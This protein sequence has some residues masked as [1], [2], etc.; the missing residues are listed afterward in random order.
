MNARVLAIALLP[1]VASCARDDGSPDPPV[2]PLV[3]CDTDAG[4]G[5]PLACPPAA[6][7]D[8]SASQND[9]AA[10]ID[11]AADASPSLANDAGASIDL[12][13]GGG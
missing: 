6:A 5:D 8:A 10:S 9:A 11:L 4:A 12:A 2:Q 1:L 7:I 13:E 3:L